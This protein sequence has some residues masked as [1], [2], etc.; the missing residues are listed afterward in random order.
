MSVDGGNTIYDLSTD[1]KP[2]DDVE[3]ERI[4][5]N[6]GRI[7][8]NSSV[9]N[10]QSHL[11]QQS[12]VVLGPTRVFPGRLSVSRTFGDIEAKLPKFDGNPNVVVADPDIVAF[13]IDKDRHDFICIGC[14]GIFDKMESKDAIHCDWQAALSSEAQQPNIQLHSSTEEE[15]AQRKLNAQ[16]NNKKTKLSPQDERRHKL[17][18]HTVDAILKAS[19][20]RKTCDNIT[21]V[22]ITFDN[23]YKNLD[24]MRGKDHR[25]IEKEVLDIVQLEPVP[26]DY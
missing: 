23:F 10:Q 20:I 17:A 12:Q 5:G 22:L 26:E 2:T 8:Q 24:E 9:V 7:Y 13:K 18:G 19:S 3:M 16:S 25:S 21:T 14:D 15:E 4:L 11:G 1:H 6:G